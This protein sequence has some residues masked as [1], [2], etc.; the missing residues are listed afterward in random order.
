MTT[1]CLNCKRRCKVTFCKKCVKELSMG[2]RVH[3]YLKN[4]K[5][6]KGGFI[7]KNGK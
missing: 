6:M 7:K 2:R 5:H 1:K 3:L 4:L